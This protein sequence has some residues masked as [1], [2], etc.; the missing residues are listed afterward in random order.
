MLG[1]VVGFAVCGE[2][3]RNN[4][5][6]AS[7]RVVTQSKKAALDNAWAALEVQIDM[8]MGFAGQGLTPSQVAHLLASRMNSL[9]LTPEDSAQL[10][11]AGVPIPE[12]V[13][14]VVGA[15]NGPWQIVLVPDDARGVVR[16]TAYGADIA[17]AVRSREF[18]VQ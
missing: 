12:P 5:R 16:L 6:E 11:A 8:N 9:V 2:M 17:T 13:P 14:H 7:G 15:P 18:P 4:A 1:V 3:M 10:R